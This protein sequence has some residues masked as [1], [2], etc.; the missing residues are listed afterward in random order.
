MTA[1]TIENPVTGERATFI[2]TSVETGGARTVADLEV[3]PGGGVPKHRHADHDERIEVLEGEI[4]VTIEGKKHVLRAGEH[5]VIERGQTHSWRNASR[6]RSSFRGRMSPG[7][8]GFERFLRVLFGLARDGEV[9]S[10][11]LPRRFGDLG[12]LTEWDPSVLSGPLRLLSPLMRW[13]ARRAR[14]RGRADE[15]LQRYEGG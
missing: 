9:R 14:A 7:H 6:E 4:E 1:R 12:L 13:S 8:P 10:N 3:T 5:I 2:E 11:G 15:L